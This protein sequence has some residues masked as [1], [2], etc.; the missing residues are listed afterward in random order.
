MRHSWSVRLRT[1]GHTHFNTRTHPLQHKDTPTWTQGHTHLNTAE[2][3]SLDPAIIL[4]VW[5]SWK[6][7][8]SRQDLNSCAA[9]ADG[10]CTAG[11]APAE[12]RVLA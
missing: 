1:Q 3:P 10:R 8:A 9:G 7:C 12:G 6:P 11:W 5:I 2:P 4:G